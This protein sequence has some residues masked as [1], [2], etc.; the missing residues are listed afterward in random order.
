M[1]QKLSVLIDAPSTNFYPVSPEVGKAI[2]HS[3]VVFRLRIE[4]VEG[5]KSVTA[6]RLIDQRGEEQLDSTS[7]ALR[8]GNPFFFLF[9]REV[10]FQATWGLGHFSSS[11]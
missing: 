11:R 2:Y 9:P 1:A 8:L 6:S 7:Q 10:R 4:K 3:W 5:V